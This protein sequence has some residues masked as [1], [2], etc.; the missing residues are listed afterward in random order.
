MKT[1]KTTPVAVWLNL[2][3]LVMDHKWLV[4]DL[5]QDHTGGMPWNGYRALRRVE[6]EPLSQG[7]LAERMHIDAPA[8]SVLVGE[9]VD[10]AYVERVPDPRD[11]RR[12]LVRITDAGRSLVESLRATTDVVPAPVST[13]TAAER[14]ELT[15][16][17]DKMRAAGEVRE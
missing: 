6:R 8:A 3:A 9:L 11:G 15:R 16:L 4:R 7:Q 5:L 2:A 13:L 10:R 17:I 1:T 12:K 14:R